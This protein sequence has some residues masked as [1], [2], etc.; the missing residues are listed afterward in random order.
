MNNCSLNI[1]KVHPLYEQFY[2]MQSVGNLMKEQFSVNMLKFPIDEPT[3]NMVKVWPCS[4]TGCTA[5]SGFKPWS[6]HVGFV[7]DKAALGQLFPQ[8]FCFPCQ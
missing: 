4:S 8:Y 2:F 6:G 1:I 5:S 3:R 7:V